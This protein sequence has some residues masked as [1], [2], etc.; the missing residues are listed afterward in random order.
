MK[1]EYNIKTVLEIIFKIT[2]KNADILAHT[3]LLK[4]KSIISKWRNNKAIPRND[5]ISKI[6]EFVVNES[7]LSQ[8]KIIR[9]N[10]EKLI[11][12]EPLKEDIK[13]IILNASAFTEFLQ[14]ALSV[15]I[16]INESDLEPQSYKNKKGS[17]KN[18]ISGNIKN[19]NRSYKGTLEFD[20]VM[21]EERETKY[22]KVSSDSGMELD[23]KISITPNNPLARVPRYLKKASV[24]GIILIIGVSTLALV[25][26]HG[27]NI[28][29]RK[30][31][32]VLNN[33]NINSIKV[34]ESPVFSPTHEVKAT[35]VKSPRPSPVNS[36]K[37]SKAPD[38][39]NNSQ[40]IS[41]KVTN[42]ISNK[43]K[44]SN[45]T[46]KTTVNNSN[47][48]TINNSGNHVIIV[49]GNQNSIGFESN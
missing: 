16:S 48:T 32:K 46:T 42:N 7:T 34:V 26:S 1:C 12:N 19:K 18:N 8:Q 43:T 25:F 10:I 11:V 28:N 4:D 29:Q 13:N 2:K 41:K 20:L 23:G 44:I 45:K 17:E 35:P 14:E 3:Y 15:A 36:P 33:K 47:K 40:N 22:I 38:M 6:V 37:N 30:D 49:S 31:L 24:M 39:E 21:P 27:S 9:D 5:D